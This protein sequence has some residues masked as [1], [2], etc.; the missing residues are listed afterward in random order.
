MPKDT[1]NQTPT[2]P[3]VTSEPTAQHFEFARIYWRIGSARKAGLEMWPDLKSAGAKGEKWFKR[4]DVQKAIEVVREAAQD[5]IRYLY[6]EEDCGLKDIVRLIAKRVTDPETPAREFK[7]LAIHALDMM[8][9]SPKTDKKD[10]PSGNFLE[11]LVGAAGL[12][13]AIG[14]NISGRRL[15]DL[16]PELSVCPDERTGTPA[17][18]TLVTPGTDVAGPARPEVEQ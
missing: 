14:S 7:E 2:S 16:R 8:G 4:P 1:S 5:R 17:V 18:P 11:Q 15:P 3:P 12:G 6:A 13:A 10:R 9:H